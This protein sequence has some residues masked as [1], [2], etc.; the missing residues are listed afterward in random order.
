MLWLLTNSNFE[1]KRALDLILNIYLENKL[2][3]EKKDTHCCYLA[4]AIW[5]S[6][7][8]TVR[9]FFDKIL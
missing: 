7:R 8:N 6:D 1:K 9:K 2:A 5:I 3:M 4:E